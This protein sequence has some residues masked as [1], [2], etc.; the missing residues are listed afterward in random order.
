MLDHLKMKLAAEWHRLVTGTENDCVA[1]LEWIEHIFKKEYDMTLEEIGT[2][3]TDI[4][5][6][7]ETPAPAPTVDLSP[8][9]NAVAD[10]KTEVMTKVEGT[11]AAT[12]PVA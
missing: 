10:L 6:L 1:V 4:K 5:K 11:P 3:L 2:A 7:L 8:V 12:P 9:L